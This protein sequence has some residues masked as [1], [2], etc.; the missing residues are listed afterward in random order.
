MEY[1]MTTALDILVGK[2]ELWFKESVSAFPNICVAVLVVTVFYYVSKF[3]RK[4]SHSFLV[5]F[6]MNKALNDLMASSLQ[7]TVVLVGIFIALGILNLEKT[8]TS[9]LAGAGIITFVIGFAFQDI[10][11]NFFSGILIAFKKPYQIGDVIEIDKNLGVVEEI[12]L[13]STMIRTFDGQDI[14]IPNKNILTHV[15]TNYTLSPYRRVVV[16]VGVSYDSDLKKVEEVTL[17]ALESVPE[18]VMDQPTEVVFTDFGA[19]SINL[20]AAFWMD[21]Q[22]NRTFL[23]AR[24]NA[25]LAINKAYKENGIQIPFPITQ[26]ILPEAGNK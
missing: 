5:R 18:R 10:A 1:I 20:S 22:K 7:L 8:V 26:V 4:I 15:V 9:L 24:H 16:P 19:S 25:I 17:K 13:R 23:I 12:E 2:I 14:L 21:Y 6:S 3:V 11:S